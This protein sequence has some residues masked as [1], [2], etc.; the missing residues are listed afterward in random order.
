[1]KFGCILLD[2]AWTYQDK[3]LAGN[4]GAGCKYSLMTLDDMKQ[5]PVADLADDDCVMFVWATFPLL[6][7]GLDLIRAYGFTF[8]TVAFTWVKTTS[9]G[10]YSIG[11]GRWSRSN[12]EIVM[13]A[14]KGKP[15]RVDAGV[16]Q[17]VAAPRGKHSAKPPEVRDRIV[18]LLG[19]IPRVELFAREQVGDW[20][21]LGN[22]IDGQDLRDSI[23]ELAAM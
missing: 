18:R 22:E 16:N 6:Q 8:K 17:I 20:V 21:A 13:L 4:R 14:T 15:K 12:A 1:M 23:P 10:T 2:P 5:L 11:M 19:D 3:A 9:K 7:E